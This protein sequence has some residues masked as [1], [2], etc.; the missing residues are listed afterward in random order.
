MNKEITSARRGLTIN[1]DTFWATYLGLISRINLFLL[2]PKPKP[3]RINFDN[4]KFLGYTFD[5]ELAT[6]WVIFELVADYKI[7]K[8]DNFFSFK[9]ICT[10]HEMTTKKQS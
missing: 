9:L 6:V 8:F 7:I 3:F 10:F 5:A 2:K 4:S 1:I